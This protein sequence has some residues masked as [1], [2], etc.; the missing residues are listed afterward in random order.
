[1]DERVDAAFQKILRS[2]SVREQSSKR[3]REKLEKAG[4][5]DDVVD[6]ALDRAMRMRAI[7]DTRYADALIRSSISAGK[8]LVFAL[9]EIEDLNVDPLTLDSYQAYL[10]EGSDADVERAVALLKRHPPRAKNVRES[11]F[12]KLVSKG[13]ETSV[14]STAARIFS[15][16]LPCD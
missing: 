6:E 15:A 13:Y 8:G 1:M 11:A 2:V 5:E 9:R 10:E 4:F 3:M 14:A 16:E 7:D 12:R